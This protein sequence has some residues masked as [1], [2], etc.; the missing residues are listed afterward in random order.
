[1]TQSLELLAETTTTPAER[2]IPLWLKVAYTAFMS[3]LI[4]VYWTSYGPLNFLWF[5]D[6][7]L[8]LT[9]VA[10]WTESPLI[11]SIPAVGIVFPQ[12]IW[13]ADFVIALCGGGSPLGMSGY[14]FDTN[15]SLV[16]RGLS[17]FHGWLP[18]L[19]IYLTL[20]LGYDRRSLAWQVICC[21]CVLIASFLLMNASF[22]PAEWKSLA[23]NL[24]KLQ[25]PKDDAAQT[26]MPPAAWLAFLMVAYPL[27]IYV[28]SHFAFRRMF[29]GQAER[30]QQVVA[31]PSMAE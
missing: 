28:P 19:L 27:M 31:S 14:M 13:V 22:I 8:L 7:A 11:A 17:T 12:M 9:L 6:V 3:V 29:P 25:G 10:V 21:W 5:C 15:Y 18:F 1:M 30:L 16:A 4:P 23:G 26:W 24:N 20:R 2:R